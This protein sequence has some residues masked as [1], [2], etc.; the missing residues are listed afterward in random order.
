MRSALEQLITDLAAQARAKIGTAS[1][2]DDL[3]LLAD[4][5]KRAA[6]TLLI[7]QSVETNDEFNRLHR[8]QHAEGQGAGFLQ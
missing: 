7:V 3:P 4:S 8:D 6:E 2:N 1:E 5:M